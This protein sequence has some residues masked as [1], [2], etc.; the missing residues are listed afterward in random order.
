MKYR[1]IK[2]FSVSLETVHLTAMF[3]LWIYAEKSKNVSKKNNLPTDSEQSSTDE[4]WCPPLCGFESV[5]LWLIIPLSHD[6]TI[7]GVSTSCVPYKLSSAGSWT[8]ISEHSSLLQFLGV[9]I[10][11]PVTSSPGKLAASEFWNEIWIIKIRNLKFFEKKYLTSYG[12]CGECM[13]GF[14]VAVSSGK[15]ISF[16]RSDRSGQRL[17]FR[18]SSLRWADRSITISIVAFWF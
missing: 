9:G 15:P 10:R 12:F 6:S 11:S 17:L 3:R 14:P 18:G 2:I 5:E 8:I 7:Y 13:K 4:V 16:N 1:F